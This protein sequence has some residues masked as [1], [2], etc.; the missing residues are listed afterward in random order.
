M[1]ILLQLA[2]AHDYKYCHPSLPAP[3]SFGSEQNAAKRIP[4]MPTGNRKQFYLPSP[5]VECRWFTA[6]HG[7]KI[8][9]T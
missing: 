1:R 5:V 3:I 7:P 2:R 6:G 8:Y 4:R 9:S